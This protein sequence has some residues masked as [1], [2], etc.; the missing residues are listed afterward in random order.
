MAV[1]HVVKPRTLALLLPLVFALHNGEEAFTI[2][3]FL[4]L[5]KAQLPSWAAAW[6]RDVTVPLYLAGLAIVTTLG[7]LAGLWVLLRPRSRAALWTLLLLQA[8]L[9]LNAFSHLL[10]AALLR[11]YDPGVATAALVNLP[12]SLYVFRTASR[13]AWLARGPLLAL[14]PAAVL[15]HGPLLMALFALLEWLR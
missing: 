2:G 3:P 12:L 8:V 9:L 11:G 5:L 15:V 13:E 14:I 4:P 10:T 1:M 7:L 6:T